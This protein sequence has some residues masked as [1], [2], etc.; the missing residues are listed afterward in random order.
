MVKCLIEQDGINA[1]LSKSGPSKVRTALYLHRLLQRPSRLGNSTYRS[2]LFFSTGLMV[3]WE[4]V[5]RN[6]QIYEYS[7]QSLE[8]SPISSAIMSSAS[9]Q[10]PC[11]MRDVNNTLSMSS[12]DT[13]PYCLLPRPSVKTWLTTL[14]LGPSFP[15]SRASTST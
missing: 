5:T 4:R 6:A 12:S 2:Q 8:S 15:I 9:Q 1:C 10:A 11:R 3:C 13:R 7:S 14:F